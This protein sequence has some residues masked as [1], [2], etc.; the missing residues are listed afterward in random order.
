MSFMTLTFGAI[1]DLCFVH[2]KFQLAFSKPLRDS[3]FKEFGLLNTRT[4]YN[5][6]I[7]VSFKLDVIRFQSLYRLPGKFS[8]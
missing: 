7:A 6:I 8:A 2:V 4:V 1:H 3:L 5:D